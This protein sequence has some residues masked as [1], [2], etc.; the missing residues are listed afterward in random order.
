MT[1]SRYISWLEKKGTALFRAAGTCWTLYHGALV[2]ASPF[3]DYHDLN[4]GEAR[5]LLKAS[6]AWFIR[7]SRDPCNHE[8]PWWY[9][10]CDHYDPAT[11]NA[12]T[13]QNIRRGRRE[14]A[15]REVDATWLAD[16]GYPCYAAAFVR[17]GGR[18]PLS[19]GGFQKMILDTREGPFS[20][21][22]VFHEGHLAGY[23]QC[24]VDGGQV[25][26]NVTKYHP[27]YLRHRSAY[28]LIDALIQTYAVGRGMTLS[29][30]NRSIAHGTNYQDVLEN[31]G[32]RRQFCRLAVVYN[33]WLELCMDALYPLRPI[34]KR[35]PD[36]HVIHEI[37]ALIRQE[38]IRRAKPGPA[39]QLSPRT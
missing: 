15:V 22:G 2:P 33:P 34:L 24:I 23:C 8:T 3:P 16:H 7:Y 21:W 1:E 39:V 6:G 27:S 5:S 13:R 19:E 37:G 26:T 29:N 25:S 4:P 14:C 38:E 18:R 12:K 9:V 17:Y 11:I 20:Y 35:L 10:V 30:G 31:L 28:A 32:F 36:R